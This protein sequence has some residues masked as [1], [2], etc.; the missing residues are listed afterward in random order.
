MPT[1]YN[2]ELECKPFHTMAVG[3][4]GTAAVQSVYRVQ[5]PFFTNKSDILPNCEL[6][7]ELV[8]QKKKEPKAATWK[9]ESLAASRKAA[10][11]ACKPAGPPPKKI[12]TGFDR[13]D[14]GEI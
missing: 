3:S 1:T 4:T 9:D 5:V 13:L 2:L 6:I 7:A 14:V 10:A 11:A 8:P 12:K